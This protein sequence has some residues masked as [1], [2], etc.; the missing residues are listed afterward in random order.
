M[1]NPAELRRLR[2]ARAALVAEFVWPEALRRDAAA[3]G[4]LQYSKQRQNSPSP[5]LGSDRIGLAVVLEGLHDVPQDGAVAAHLV[6]ERDAPG[7][8]R[9]ARGGAQS[10]P[11]APGP[12]N[13]FPPPP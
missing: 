13:P 7:R 3:A 9:L 12:P 10:D 8:G 6:V 4:A 5:R 1:R 11:G 2:R